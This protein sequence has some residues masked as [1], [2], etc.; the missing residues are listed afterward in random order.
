MARFVIDHPAPPGGWDE[1]RPRLKTALAG[2]L[3]VRLEERWDGDSLHLSGAGARAS[4]RVVDGH[5][6]AEADLRPPASFFR[7]VIERELRH[8]MQRAWPVDGG[9]D[10]TESNG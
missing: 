1:V 7:G 8:A 9:A 3:P 5:L 10:P 6:R 4:I 2:E